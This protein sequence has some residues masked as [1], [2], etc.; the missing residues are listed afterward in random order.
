MVWLNPWYGG[1]FPI[2]YSLAFISTVIAAS[3]VLSFVFPKRRTTAGQ[4]TTALPAAK[5][6]G[7]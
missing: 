6:D 1:K 7:P 5:P 2:S 4:A 3:V